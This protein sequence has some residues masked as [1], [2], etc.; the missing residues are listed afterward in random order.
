MVQYV[1]TAFHMSCPLV[2][3]ALF[4]HYSLAC[5]QNAGACYAAIACQRQ[6]AM[7][8]QLRQSTVLQFKI[9]PFK[10]PV[11]MDPKYGGEES[12][13]VLVC[14]IRSKAWPR[15]CFGHA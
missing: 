8:M 3:Q 15:P 7:V 9:E 1:L 6:L 5:T 2:S 12:T 11:K 14:P 10:H 4:A 13:P